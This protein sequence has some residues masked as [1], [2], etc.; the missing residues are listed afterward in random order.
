M[1]S[2]TQD[3]LPWIT[4]GLWITAAGLFFYSSILGR[5]ALKTQIMAAMAQ[6]K[7]MMSV[8]ERQESV[9]RALIAKGVLSPL[10]LMDSLR[11]VC[12]RREGPLH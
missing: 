9:E 10:E 4:T 8:L 6:H 5:R 3:V 2:I 11:D 1:V 7:L 12:E